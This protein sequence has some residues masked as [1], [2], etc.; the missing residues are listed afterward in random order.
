MQTDLRR[1]VAAVHYVIART[2]PSK[3]GYVKLNKILWY[4]DIEH[5]QRH[6]RSLTGL[7]HYIRMPQ[8]PMSKDISR[9]IRNLRKDGKVT[10]RRVK[11]ID[12]DRRELI[13][14]KEPSLS[15]FNA[16][17]IDILNRVIDAIVPLTADEV[18]RLTHEDELWKEL[19]DND[20]LAIGPASIVARPPTPKQLEWAL[21]QV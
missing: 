18:S 3:L 17:Q 13:W 11:V 4:A 1:L 7:T 19:K 15:E 20:P 14:L 2:D 6:S 8:G 5:Y 9:A 12:Y 10:E 16:E 21:A